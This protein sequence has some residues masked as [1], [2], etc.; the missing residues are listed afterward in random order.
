M[1]RPL[2]ESRHRSRQMQAALEESAIGRAQ[3]Q[4]LSG[5]A[6]SSAATLA[7]GAVS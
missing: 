5:D 4:M 7:V 2:A 3:M 1:Q 6:A